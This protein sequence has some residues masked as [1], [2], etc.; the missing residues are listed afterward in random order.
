[1]NAYGEDTARR[2]TRGATVRSIGFAASNLLTAVG[3]IFLLRA[4]GVVDFGRYGVVMALLA[5]VSGV[6]DAGLT[7]TA[8]RELARIDSPEERR[9]L[10][11]DVLAARM[12][13]A[14][15]GVGLAVLFGVIV[16]YDHVLVAGTAVAGVGVVLISIQAALLLPLGVEL[17]QGRITVS[18][19]IRQGLVVAGLVAL[20]LAN[21]KLIW[22]F[23]LHIA[24]GAI[25]LLL[26]PVLLGRGVVPR[27]HWASERMRA[28]LRRA[29]PVAI[30]SILAMVY[31]RVLVLIT[32]VMATPYENGLFV[33][34]ARIFELIAGLPLLLT[35]VVLPVLSAAARDDPGRMRYVTQRMTEV[36][37]VG[38]VL[39]VLVVAIAAEPLLRVLGGA[40]YVPAAPVVRWQAIALIT[41]FLISAWNPVLIALGRQRAMAWTAA[42]GLT[43]AIAA[44]LILVPILHAK[45][46][47]IATV[48]ADL[49]NA[50]AVLFVLRRIGPGLE[51]SFGFLPRLFVVTAVA[52]AIALVSPLPAAVTAVVVA[53][54]YLGLAALLR[55]FPEE[56]THLLPARMR[57]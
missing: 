34:S 9:E 19:I 11:G 30:T 52:V 51:V 54:V 57:A 20:A 14:T 35:G 17:R 4:L 40:E 12:G 2:V 46:A 41:L 42:I 48:I 32:S 8:S 26:T 37:A 22:F 39:I 27:I 53:V 3:S 36:A 49:I 28:L 50:A 38:S 10:L 13:L 18:E 1:M 25:L 56:A 47:A 43:A 21:A 23:A 55:L 6:T 33:T 45:G 29:L 15:L 7:I 44:G 16:G 24:V 31:F 5:L